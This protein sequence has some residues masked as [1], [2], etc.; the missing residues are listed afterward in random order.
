[1]WEP[2]A[3]RP[4]RDQDGHADRLES[5]KSIASYLGRTVRT[6]R[7][8][9]DSEGLPVHR[10]QHG[11]RATVYAYAHE[12]NAWL[13][14]RQPSGGRA[15]GSGK[16]PPN[17]RVRWLRPTL[18]IAVPAA[19][20]LAV[21]LFG[22][23]GGGV[24][25]GPVAGHAPNAPQVARPSTS[26]VLYQEGRDHLDRLNGAG[27]ARSVLEEAVVL[28]PADARIHAALGEAYARLALRAPRPAL[29][30]LA[31]VEVNLALALDGRLARGHA[32]L[33]F[34]RAYR[35]WD[36]SGARAAFEQALALDPVD[37]NVRSGFASMLRA[38]GQ[39]TEAIVERR[40]ACERLPL[41]PG[42]W[43]QLGLDLVFGREYDEAAASFRRALHLSPG[44]LMAI[45][46]LAGALELAGRA[47]EAARTRSR[48]LAMAGRPE[49]ALAFEDQWRRNGYGAA[50]RWLDRRD[51]QRLDAAG[52][53]SS[54]WERA[55]RL[56]RLG[57]A[58]Q[59]V[60]AL[61]AALDR[62]DPGVLQ[63]GIDPDL[64]GIRHDPRFQRIVDRRDALVH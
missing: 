37:A 52:E 29:W 1:M 14:L 55:W 49:D 31:G 50:A 2:A 62:R 40:R 43:S 19:V 56:A 28:A 48:A 32:A 15:P 42:L 36:F 60:V 27:R 7:R 13:A 54:P 38:S 34:L 57:D 33:G 8:W 18:A 39:I 20:L 11:D 16:G 10:H 3:A 30:P 21:V 41:Q 51:L 58:R 26:E 63:I 59:A 6:V 45:Q 53:S 23:H 24:Y 25:G 12:L 64:D 22:R 4:P 5:W 9:E 44:S 17:D 46:G 35:D 47:D 61:E